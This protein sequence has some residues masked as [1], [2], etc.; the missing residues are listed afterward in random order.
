M[1]YIEFL[2]FVEYHYYTNQVS[3]IS[4]AN[5]AVKSGFCIFFFRIGSWLL[6]FK[7]QKEVEKLIFLH[8]PHT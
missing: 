8:R 1:S 6:G 2:I 3:V 5:L 7:M 4:G